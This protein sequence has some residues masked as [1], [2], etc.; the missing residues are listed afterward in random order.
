VNLRF[1][2]KKKPDRVDPEENE[3]ARIFA[4]GF[5]RQCLEWITSAD[6]AY[7]GGTQGQRYALAC[8]RL[9][10]SEQE[11]TGIVRE[12]A[13]ACRDSGIEFNFQ[14]LVSAIAVKQ[15]LST[16]ACQIEAYCQ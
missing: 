12:A 8:S 3:E 16:L 4:D 7:P 2:S 10:Y 13:I 15:Y 6:E 9:G 5:A 14:A 1:W 11:L